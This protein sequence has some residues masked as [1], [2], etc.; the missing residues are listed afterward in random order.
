MLSRSFP[1]RS[2]ATTR[3]L[4]IGALL[5]PRPSRPSRRVVV[6]ALSHA[7]AASRRWRPSH[8]SRKTGTP[9][10]AALACAQVASSNAC[11]PTSRSAPGRLDH[12]RQLRH[13]RGPSLDFDEEPLALRH[14][15]E[16]FSQRW[17]PLPSPLGA[18]PRTRVETLQLRQ[19]MPRHDK[20]DAR[21][22]QRSLVVHDKN[23]AVRRG[24]KRPARTCAS[25]SSR[26][27]KAASV[28]SGAR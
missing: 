7:F 21:G 10:R 16:N 9:G 19:R 27:G 22:A 14:V 1:A 17:H 5:T 24:A 2:S 28:F 15:R 25:P 3:S 18:L 13:D 26:G 6:R 20:I 4:R 11:K 12:P 8:A 23:A